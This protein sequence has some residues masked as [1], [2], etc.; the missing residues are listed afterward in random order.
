MTYRCVHCRDSGWVCEN[1]LSTPW[2]DGDGCHCGGAGTNCVCNPTGDTRG[3]F[4]VVYESNDPNIPK[5]PI[6]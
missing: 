1:H 2:G 4:A 3:V 5:T 6:H